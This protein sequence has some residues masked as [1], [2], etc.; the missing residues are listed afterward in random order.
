MNGAADPTVAGDEDPTVVRIASPPQLRVQKIS[1]DM[2][3]DPNVLLPGDTLRYTITVKN[4]GGTDVPDAVLRDELPAN[5]LYVADS[6]TLNGT[7]VADGPGGSLPL[8]HGHSDQRARRSDA[9]P[10]ARRSLAHREQRGDDRVRRRDRRGRARRDGD[11]EPG[12]RRR[13]ERRARSALGRSRHRDSGRSDPRRGRRR[14]AALRA[15]ECGP[16]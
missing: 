5:T 11:L 12:I 8:V 4:V 16:R 14:A 13:V 9:R 2:T 3:G 7:A 15:E 10:P 1:T 6:T